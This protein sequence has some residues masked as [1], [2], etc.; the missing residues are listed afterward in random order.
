[1]AYA[2]LEI[3]AMVEGTD[4]IGWIRSSCGKMLKWVIEWSLAS[5]VVPDSVNLH[6]LFD[7]FVPE[8]Q[9]NGAIGVWVDSRIV[10]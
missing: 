10:W 3:A 5:V 7:G 8:R 2:V 9:G 6:F 1:V 4:C